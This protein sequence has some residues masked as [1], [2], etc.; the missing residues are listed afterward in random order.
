M[1][2]KLNPLERER[3]L[4]WHLSQTEYDLRIAESLV[5]ISPKWSII[6]AYY[7]MHNAAKYYLGKVFSIKVVPPQTHETVVRELERRTL[8]NPTCQEIKRLIESAKEEFD[9]LT[10]ADP[11]IIHQQYRQGKEK[12]EKQ[13][14][15]SSHSIRKED[16]KDFIKNI[17]KPFQKIM[18][19]L[20]E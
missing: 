15:Y 11:A 18:V 4:K 6:I 8:K 9:I 13:S 17:A 1:I 19:E 10:Y 16:P 5:L 2:T 3:Y 12:R 20:G 14:Y 7:S